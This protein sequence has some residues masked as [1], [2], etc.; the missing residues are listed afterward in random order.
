MTERYLAGQG[1]DSFTPEDL[2]TGE[3]Q[4]VT[5][6]IVVASGAG[7]VESRSV[8][9]IITASGKALLSDNAASDGSEVPNCILVHEI[10]ATSADVEAA[11]YFEGCF[12]PELLVLGGTHSEV[13][14]AAALRDSGIY[15]KTPA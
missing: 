6:T 2:I 5:G 3:K 1:S 8:L 10:D 7:V 13:T 9:G 15:L 11:V 14:I 4:I 12:N